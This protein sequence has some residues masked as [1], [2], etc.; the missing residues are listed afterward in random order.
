[1]DGKKSAIQVQVLYKHLAFGHY[2]LTELALEYL[3]EQT[4]YLI[5]LK[6]PCV[7]TAFHLVSTKVQLF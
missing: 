3:Q 2:D 1:M 4:L 7:R 6:I 5:I